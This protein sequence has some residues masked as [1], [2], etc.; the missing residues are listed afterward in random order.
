MYYLDTSVLVPLFVKEKKSSLVRQFFEQYSQHTELAISIWTVTEFT[1]AIG[2]KVRLKEFSDDLAKKAIK[3]F[4]EAFQKNITVFSL[5]DADFNLAVEYLTE[6][7]LGLRA[8]DAL[9]LAIAQRQNA[10]KFFTFDQKL[11]E[12]APKFKLQIVSL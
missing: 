7:S 12:L 11:L 2:M 9:H 8:G 10:K 6:F 5:E 1:S 4:K 3:I